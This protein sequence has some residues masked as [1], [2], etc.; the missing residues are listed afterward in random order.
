MV[1]LALIGFGHVGRAFARL[2]LRQEQVLRD[3]HGLQWCVTAIITRS[4]GWAC[5]ER[6]LDLPALLEKPELPERS[7]VLPIRS[8]PCDVLF[9][10]STLNAKDGQPALDHVRE[11]LEAGI[12]VVTAN[13]GPIAHGY[14]ELS[15][16]AGRSGRVLRFEATIADNLPV[17]NL[18]RHA[19]PT[20]R[21]VSLRGIVNSTTNYILTEVAR[22]KT[23]R[24][25]LQEA[26][27]LGLAER[28]PSLDLEGWDAAVKATILANVLLGL[29][30]RVADVVREPVNEM[31]AVQAA[32]AARDGQRLRPV[33]T[34]DRRQARWAPVILSPDDALYA[35]DGLSMALELE[36]DVAGRL[37]VVL[38][39][40]HVEQVA[41]AL[42]ADL[43]SLPRGS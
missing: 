7:P 34:I 19:L 27:R 30:L 1:R 31:V 10:V 18:M 13:K 39:D 6:G 11:A 5:D 35:V 22:G 36:T 24:L 17:F 40:P 23:L 12:H 25:A 26:Q 14:R 21:I 15:D 8:L 20:A 29:P 33:L 41:F 43:V 37:T 38:H 9:E 32:Q 4:H 16:L 2:L 3:E 28:D 42:L